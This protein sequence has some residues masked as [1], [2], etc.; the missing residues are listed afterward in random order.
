MDYLP[1]GTLCEGA[2]LSLHVGDMLDVTE[3]NYEEGRT[4]KTES[5]QI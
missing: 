2:S 3:D 1:R 4:V 5:I